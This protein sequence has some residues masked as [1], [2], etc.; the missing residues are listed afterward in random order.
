MNWDT[1]QQLLSIVLYSLCAFLLGDSVAQGDLFQGFIGGAVNVG[2]FVWWWFW[3]RNR[4]AGEAL[5]L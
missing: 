2:A 1:I 4:P 5:E 3:E